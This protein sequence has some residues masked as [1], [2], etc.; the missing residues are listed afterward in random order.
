MQPA[1][2]ISDNSIKYA[3]VLIRRLDNMQGAA[4]ILEYVT[5]VKKEP[6][7]DLA[8][9]EKSLMY[10]SNKPHNFAIGV[11]LMGKTLEKS[12]I[13][14]EI[15]ELIDSYKVSREDIIIEIN[16]DT[17]FSSKHAI[18]NINTLH[19]NNIKMA[20]DDFGTSKANLGTLIINDTKLFD[21]I[22][23]D[24]KFVDGIDNGSRTKIDMLNILHM[25][26]MYMNTESIIEGIET[27]EQLNIAKTIGFDTVQGYIFSKPIEM[28]KF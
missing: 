20:L 2:S 27:I 5:E 22:K 8:V 25:I 21:I 7:F 12:N 14:K 9:L 3:E 6:E 18:Q 19:N 1:Y 26:C 24:K 17:D 23:I 15:I 10:I 16:E 13:S 28:S 11:N 4:K